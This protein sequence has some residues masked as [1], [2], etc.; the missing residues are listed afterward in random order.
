MTKVLRFK[1]LQTKMLAITVPLVLLTTAA[2]F[3]LIQKNVEQNALKDLET[4]LEN[5][6]AVH[7]A[8]LTGPLWQ[9]DSAQA[10]LSLDAL[11]IDEDVIG[12]I[13][14]DETDNVIAQV[15]SMDAEDVTVYTRT[16][17]INYDNGGSLVL[18]GTL[19]VAMTD[20]RL[21]A[22]TKERQREAALIGALLV[23]VIVLSV[24]L[25]HRRIVGIPLN[26]LTDSIQLFQNTKERQPVNWSSN[27]EMGG[28]ISAFNVMQQQQEADQNELQLAR[29]N[30]EQRV[31]ERTNAL[32]QREKQLAELVNDLEEARDS[33]EAANEAKSNFLATMSHEIRTPMNSVIGMSGLLL[34]SPLNDEQRE[35]TKILRRSGEDLLSIINDILD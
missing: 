15:G 17:P 31:E 21:L 5:V 8:S 13:V 16:S 19:Q 23:G 28:V 20:R 2:M 1:S 35:V 22:A 25:A 12:A 11:V 9:V 4:R 6:T 34:D 18:I 33:A 30:L 7:S 29:D 32:K 10:S 3:F 24:V 27:D 14:L 26:R